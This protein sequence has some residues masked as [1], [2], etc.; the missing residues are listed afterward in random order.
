MQ[1][2]HHLD[3]IN[4]DYKFRQSGIDDILDNLVAQIISD[5]LFLQIKP[6]IPVQYIKGGVSCSVFYISINLIF[7]PSFSIVLDFNYFDFYC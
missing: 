5:H 2:A 4:M 3:T 7:V 6:S 1:L